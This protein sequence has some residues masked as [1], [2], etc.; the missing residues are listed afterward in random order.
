MLNEHTLKFRAQRG[1]SSP[2]LLGRY[3]FAGAMSLL[4]LL[5]KGSSIHG[6]WRFC[7]T[8]RAC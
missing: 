2:G 3:F 7:P 6:V 8:G 5:L 1:L 4:M